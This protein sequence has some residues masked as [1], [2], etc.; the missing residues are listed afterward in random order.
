MNY[1]Q[2]HRTRLLFGEDGFNH[3]R[4]SHIAIVGC[5]AVGSF[6]IEA[7]ARAGIGCLTL[8][9][10]DNVEITNINRQ[11]CA[12]HSTVDQPQTEVLKKRIFDIC[13]DTT[14]Y[15]KN[16]FIT[17]DNC[18]SLW[19][20]KPDFVIDAIDTI[21][22][23]LPLILNLQKNKIPFISSM[24]AARKTNWTKIKVA[25]FNQTRI[26]PLAAKLRR[27]LKEHKA[28]L[29]FPCIFS[30]EQPLPA[31]EANRQMGSL[32]TIT[33]LFGLVLANEVIQR[34]LKP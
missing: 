3:L 10:G 7:L 5:G 33:G 15:T 18:D 22:G 1:E 31:Q 11:L 27:L 13:P 21:T 34:I 25:P 8:I 26:C 29:S 19:D 28:D 4:H 6:A 17:P 24:G 2:F 9:D 20:I 30:T 14:V 12:L 32:I 16:I 23:K